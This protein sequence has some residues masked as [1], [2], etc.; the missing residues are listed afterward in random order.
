MQPQQSSN[1]GVFVII[2]LILCAGVAYWGLTKNDSLDAA[3]ITD[4]NS[5]AVA[6]EGADVAALLNQIRSLNIDGSLFESDSYHSLYDFTIEVP[7]QPVGRSNP[8][9]SVIDILS[10]TSA[11][12]VPNLSPTKKK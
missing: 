9:A 4:P 11:V 8:F 7:I 5:A 6:P 3:L 10:D 2:I 12:A 1:L